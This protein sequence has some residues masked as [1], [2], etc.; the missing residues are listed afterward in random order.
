LEVQVGLADKH[1]DEIQTND[2][3]LDEYVHPRALLTF[4]VFMRA[5]LAIPSI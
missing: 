3:M 5:L 2:Y 1:W 4:M